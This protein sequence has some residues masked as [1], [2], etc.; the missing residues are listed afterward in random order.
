VAFLDLSL[1][2]AA[3]SAAPQAAPRFSELERIVIRIG[4][5]DCL[6][7]LGRHPRWQ[8]TKALVFGFKPSNP[9][10]D[11]RLE[12][13]RRLVVELRHAKRVHVS[14][15]VLAAVRDGVTP[16]QAGALARRFHPRPRRWRWLLP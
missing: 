16:D 6:S 11:P 8:R 14:E 10:S 15:L 5:E 2:R 4:A 12:A 3:R 1:D 13:I 9:L 7:T